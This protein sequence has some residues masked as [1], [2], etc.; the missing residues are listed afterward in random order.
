[1][2]HGQCSLTQ[3]RGK[4]VKAHI[5]PRALSLVPPGDSAM[6]QTGEG[7]VPVRRRTSWYDKE[8]VT[9]AGEDVLSNHDAAGIRLLRENR[10][11]WSSWGDAPSLG[12]ALT[13][14]GN[15]GQLVQVPGAEFGIRRITSV[16]TRALRLFLLSLLWR[17]AASRLWEFV[18]IE[19]PAPELESLRLSVLT[20]R[21]E[22]ALVGSAMLVQHSTKGPSHNLTPFP[23]DL[24]GDPG[25]D[26]VPGFRFYFD[27]LI[28][29]FFR[30]QPRPAD[31]ARFGNLILGSA[32][33]L[34]VPVV[35][36]EAS[37][38]DQNLRKT[39]A[40]YRHN[41]PVRLVKP[42]PQVADD[43]RR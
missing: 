22:L 39:I 36:Y 18:K 33:E 37:F 27:G 13:T 8:L 5:I 34:L 9:R 1:M 17:A 21:P 7:S 42:V 15:R 30:H 14:S 32:H 25:M 19:V 26:S 11:V 16:D 41:W 23:V 4:F 3:Q 35:R 20:G 38:Q 10:L 31:L 2:S 43:D 28:V 29:H 6:V 40:E 24:G 12:E